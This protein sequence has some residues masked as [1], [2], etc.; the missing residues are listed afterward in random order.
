MASLRPPRRV[1]QHFGDIELTDSHGAF[2]HFAIDNASF[3]ILSHQ[4][5]DEKLGQTIRSFDLG[6][7]YFQSRRFIRNMAD[8]TGQ[9]FFEHNEFLNWKESASSATLLLTGSKHQGKSVLASEFTKHPP[10]ES[11]L[12]YFFFNDRNEKAASPAVAVATMLHQWFSK[13]QDLATI[14]AVRAFKNNANL[15]DRVDLLWDVLEQTAKEPESGALFC[16]FDALDR[17]QKDTDE[18][19]GLEALTEKIAQFY[20]TEN[21]EIHYVIRLKLLLTTRDPNLINIKNLTCKKCKSLYRINFDDSDCQDRIKRDID[22]VVSKSV[23]KAARNSLHYQ[24]GASK[25]LQSGDE[26][27]WA[28]LRIDLSKDKIPGE[29]FDSRRDLVMKWVQH[30]EGSM[31]P[32]NGS[33]CS[34]PVIAMATFE[35]DRGDMPVEGIP[36]HEAALDSPEHTRPASDAADTHSEEGLSEP[37]DSPVEA[38]DTKFH[39]PEPLRGARLRRASLLHL[40]VNSTDEMTWI[41]EQWFRSY[42]ND[43]LTRISSLERVNQ[44]VLGSVDPVKIAVL[45]TGVDLSHPR[46]RMHRPRLRAKSFLE[47]GS[48]VDDNI[49]TGTFAAGLL[50]M[51]APWAKIR[52]LKVAD[53]SAIGRSD[54]I[55]R[56]SEEALRYAD[57]DLRADLILVGYGSREQDN[58]LSDAIKKAANNGCVIFAATGNAGANE[59]AAYPARDPNVIGIYSTDGYGNRSSFNAQPLDSRDNFSTLGENVRSIRPLKLSDNDDNVYSQTGTSMSAT[60]ATAIAAALLHLLKNSAGDD[61]SER[62]IGLEA[63]RSLLRSIAV[64]RDGYKY[65]VPW[66]LLERE[67]ERTGAGYQAV[68]RLRNAFKGV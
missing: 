9:W 33:P 66:S 15:N 14:R 51:L 44:Y 3:S 56:A 57:R 30:A 25:K 36:E 17:C 2:G 60:I 67:E 45:S 49:G 23:V 65:L 38:S 27:L 52:M 4:D 10:A 58:E 68:G 24:P 55:V 42:H 64:E 13:R 26:T 61:G 21:H 48:R 20:A 7:D 40:R 43:F 32:S 46:L 47:P 63:M 31:L 37:R 19:A 16:V 62:R 5:V 22:E 35:A 1:S 39:S 6:Y 28:T 18:K 8:D 54:L 59:R 29:L 12:C 11:S 50:T 41:S 53:G 34:S